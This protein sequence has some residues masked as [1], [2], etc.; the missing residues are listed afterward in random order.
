MLTEANRLKYDD[1][2]TSV[3]L[4]RT[5]RVLSARDPNLTGRALPGVNQNDSLVGRGR[6]DTV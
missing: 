3:G 4:C 2:Q 1:S 5:Y 6:R